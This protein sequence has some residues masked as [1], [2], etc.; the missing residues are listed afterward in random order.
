[1]SSPLFSLLQSRRFYTV[2]TV[3]LTAAFWWSGLTKLFNFTDTQA[4]MLHFGLHPVT[5]FAALTIAVQLV[6]SALIITASRWAYLGAGALITFT[7][8]TIPL[9]HRFWEMD[10]LIAVLEHALVMD[11]ISVIGGLLLAA[12]LAP[13][14]RTRGTNGHAEHPV[15]QGRWSARKENPN[16]PP[17]G[18]APLRTSHYALTPTVAFSQFLRSGSATA[19][20]VDRHMH[21]NRPPFH[22]HRR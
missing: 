18:G 11:H 5:L 13:L 4:E 14:D 3:T 15:L 1:M 9:A 21:G 10:G 20:A 6:G 8:A 19:A 2:A 12:A 16:T 7:L 17:P 22:G